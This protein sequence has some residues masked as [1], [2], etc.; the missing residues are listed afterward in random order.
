MLEHVQQLNKVP[1]LDAVTVVSHYRGIP[2]EM[3]LTCKI[4]ASYLPKE[5]IEPE[6]LD[7]VQGRMSQSILTRHYLTPES[8]LSSRILSSLDSL[9]NELEKFI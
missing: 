8:N 2:M 3:H 6:V 1:T 4:F 5:G 7:M 9:K